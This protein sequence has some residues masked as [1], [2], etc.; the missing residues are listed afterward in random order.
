MLAN[1]SQRF[2]MQ[3][4]HFQYQLWK[5]GDHNRAH[6]NARVHKEK[7]PDHCRFP[8]YPAKTRKY[9]SEWKWVRSTTVANPEMFLFGNTGSP[10]QIIALNAQIS[11]RESVAID[12]ACFVGPGIKTGAF[13][14]HSA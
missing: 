13:A 12:A 14:D 6:Q 4:G 8:S 11:L 7:Q 5:C 3:P 10:L 9:A 2:V 1:S